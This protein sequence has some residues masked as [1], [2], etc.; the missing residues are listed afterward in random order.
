MRTFL[1]L[2]CGTAAL[3]AQYT[4]FDVSNMD[5]SVDPCSNF[6]QYACGNWIK[7]NPIPSDRSRWSRFEELNA[8]NEN[9]LRDILETSAAKTNG[10]AIEQKIGNYYSSCLDEKAID[11]KGTSAIKPELDRIAAMSEKSAL[12]DVLARQHMVGAAGLFNFYPRADY[13][14]AKLVIPWGDQGVLGPPGPHYYYR[15]DPKSAEIR[16]KYVAHVA[17][18]FTLLGYDSAKAAA[19]SKTVMDVEMS[20]AKASQDRVARRNANNLN[21][22]DSLD[23]LKAVTPSFNWSRYF[24]QIGI[25][26]V[27]NLNNANPEFFRNLERLLSNTSVDDLKTYLS[28]HM[29]RVSIE[30]L[31]S[32]FVKEH[33]DF[34]SRTLSGTKELRPRWKRCVDAVDHD[35]GEALGRKYVELAFAGDSKARMLQM[36]KGLEAAMA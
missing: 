11:A 13:K 21:H 18:M 6:F 16:D 3:N 27:R 1:L 31:P 25:A 36:V 17:R 7:S 4:G 30:M 8:R 5:K 34:Y 10:S 14:N 24:D 26:E 32:A 20:L 29:L 12:A 9:I 22:P 23:A 19:A 2:L 35:L 28:W 33:F 15:T